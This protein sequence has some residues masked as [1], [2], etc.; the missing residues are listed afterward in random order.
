METY[1]A[2]LALIGRTELP[3]R[4]SWEEW[5]TEHGPQHPVS[6]RIERVK[7]L[8]SLRGELLLLT[9]DVADEAEMEAAWAEIEKRFGTVHGVIH[10]AGLSGSERWI[11]QTPESAAAVLRPKVE[12]SQVLAHLLARR[13]SSA[14]DFPSVS[15][16]KSARP[17]DFLLF[18]SSVSSFSPLVGATAYAAAN[19][20]QDRYATWCRQH[21][22]L[23][24]MTVNLDAWREVGMIAEA[25]MPLEFE[26]ER[27]VRLSLAMTVE[28]GLQVFERVLALG[29]EQ[30]LVSTIDLAEVLTQVARK[31]NRSVDV[32]NPYAP[33][34]EKGGGSAPAIDTQ[35]IA[36][37]T[38]MMPETEAVIA[39]WRELLGAEQIDPQDNFFELGGHSLV[40]TMVLA[41]VREQFDVD[42]SI[43]AVFEAPTPESLG[44]RIR[45][46]EPARLV[47]PVTLQPAG[48]KVAAGDDREDFEF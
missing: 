42:L 38:P 28:E 31:A 32:L 44:A 14:G 12:G 17:L 2:K 48:E 24:A 13:H 26:P 15:R 37:Q 1:G 21:L 41:R 23:P 46:A 10:A 5:I 7:V 9:A 29:E 33:D 22:G 4:G 3:L 36:G 25:P 18:C 20:F 8:E 16:G 45:Q 11:A 40:G 30:L 39:I 47:T 19:A 34:G 6:R 43:R 27:Q 35:T